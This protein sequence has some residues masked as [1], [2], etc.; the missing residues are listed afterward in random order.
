MKNFIFC[1][2]LLNSFI[3][4]SLFAEPFVVY[5]YSENSSNK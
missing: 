2:F 4:G 1:L 5:E 3:S